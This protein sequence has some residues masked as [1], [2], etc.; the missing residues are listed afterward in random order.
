MNDWWG[1]LCLAWDAIRGLNET[2][3]QEE[4]DLSQLFGV[5]TAQEKLGTDWI[6][7]HCDVKLWDMEQKDATLRELYYVTKQL[8]RGIKNDKMEDA[9]NTLVQVVVSQGKA[10]V[11]AMN[12]YQ[13][14]NN[15]THTHVNDYVSKWERSKLV[16]EYITEKIEDMKL[17]TVIKHINV[18][19]RRNKMKDEYELVFPYY[20]ACS[21]LL[22]AKV[23]EEGY[24]KLQNKSKGRLNWFVEK[25]D[26]YD[27]EARVMPNEEDEVIKFSFNEDMDSDDEDEATDRVSTSP[28]LSAGSLESTIDLKDYCIREA[29]RRNMDPR[30]VLEEVVDKQENWL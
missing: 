6:E 8:K 5:G 14:K 29:N 21:V 23:V 7:M 22:H 20:I 9:Y 13:T 30:E 28:F 3:S 12:N 2:K 25:Y 27:I 18:C 17:E 19:D 11:E 24:G 4:F 26:Q 16:F 1:T 15:S 10:C